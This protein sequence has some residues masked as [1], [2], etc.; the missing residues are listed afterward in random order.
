MTV[1]GSREISDKEKWYLKKQKELR[2]TR[3]QLIKY[4]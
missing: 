2:L 3:T 4:G 1:E